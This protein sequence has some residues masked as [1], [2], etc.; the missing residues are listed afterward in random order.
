MK[1]LL[2]SSTFWNAVIAT[3]LIIL[4]CKIGCVN[5]GAWLTTPEIILLLFGGKQVHTTIK[6]YVRAKQG[7]E[8]DGATKTFKKIE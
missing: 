4:V 8:F 2:K 1:R 5:T 3:G 7:R 6:D